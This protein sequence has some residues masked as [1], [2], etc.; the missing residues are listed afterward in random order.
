MGSEIDPRDGH[1]PVMVNEVLELLAPEPG[2]TL[3]DAT[4]GYGGHAAR[5]LERLGPAGRLIALDQDPEALA[6]ARA[7]LADPRVEWIHGNF[8]QL[9]QHLARLEVKQI[10]GLLADLGV[11]SAQ[12]DVA[13]RGF[14]FRQSGPLDMRMNPE[15]HLTAAELIARLSAPE[16][17]RIFWEFGEERHSRKIA[18]RIVAQRPFSSTTELAEVIRAAASRP[19]RGPRRTAPIDPATRVFQALRIAVNDELGALEALLEQLPRVVRPGGRVAILSFHSLEDRRVKLAFRERNWWR[20]LTKKP[21]RASAQETASNPRARSAKLR[22][23]ERIA[24]RSLG[25]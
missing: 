4:A 16:L 12:L 23:A 5:M 22:V 7:R 6:V 21:L 17:A 8:A 3:V 9:E 1:T 20:V 10:D 15:T 13:A 18:E 24:T 19:R 25:P 11:N 2:Q 14:S